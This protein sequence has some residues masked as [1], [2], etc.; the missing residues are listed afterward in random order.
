MRTPNK[1]GTA[2]SIER[3]DPRAELDLYDDMIAAL[4]CAYRDADAAR[5][6]LDAARRDMDVAEARRLLAGGDGKNEAYGKA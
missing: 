4:D 5:R 2:P 3:S 1:N 6:E